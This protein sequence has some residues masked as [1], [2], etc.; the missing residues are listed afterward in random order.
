MALAGRMLYCPRVAA[1]RQLLK[2]EQ[3]KVRRDKREEGQEKGMK[4]R[5][6]AIYK[7]T[8]YPLCVT[9]VRYRLRNL[10]FL[11]FIILTLSIHGIYF[12]NVCITVLIKN[13]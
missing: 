9:F 2:V 10:F 11:M 12:R 6:K 7:H 1:I 3:V 13:A 5:M 4:I 8:T